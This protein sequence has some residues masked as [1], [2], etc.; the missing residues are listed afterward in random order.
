MLH[1]LRP[2]AHDRGAAPRRRALALTLVTGVIAA[3]TLAAAA[4]AS[5][6]DKPY[7]KPYSVA[8][9]VYKKVDP[10]KDAAWENSTQQFLVAAWDGKE[11]RADLTLEE[12]QAAVAEPVCGPGWGIQ[13]DKAF[14][15]TA[16]FTD[17]DKQPW[18]P[19]SYI[20]WWDS[21]KGGY[22]PG[23]LY[24]AAHWNLEDAIG[25]VPECDEV[26]PVPSATPTPVVTPSPLP[27]VP[28]VTTPSA[29]PTPVASEDPTS[30]PTPTT[31]SS[32]E[33][34][35]AP[36]PSATPTPSASTVPGASEVLNSAP[37][38]SPSFTSEVL[39]APPSG[40]VLAATGSSVGPVLAIAG[41]LVAG[42]AGLVVARQR[43][44]RQQG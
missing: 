4:P 35:A 26:A 20:G 17:P 1:G 23:K 36:T 13:Q 38:P 22:Q 10:A 11:Y 42:G 21:S 30:T 31:T 3:S 34:S 39:A 9:Y 28:P 37:S 40:R 25:S 41:V 14:G 8:A 12:I 32:G 44:A 2:S 15:T 18:Y 6:T 43:R 27:T 24:Q 19:N 33:V 29:T 7:G 5:A 16:V